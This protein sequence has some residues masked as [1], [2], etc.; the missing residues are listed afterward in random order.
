MPH[1]ARHTR[2]GSLATCV[3]VRHDRES[4]EGT[5]TDRGGRAGRDDG[6]WA[7]KAYRCYGGA[8]PPR[9]RPARPPGSLAPLRHGAPHLARTL[10]V[11]WVGITRGGLGIPYVGRIHR[12]RPRDTFLELTARGQPGPIALRAL[13]R[14]GTE[15]INLVPIEEAGRDAHRILARSLSHPARQQKKLWTLAS[16][17]DWQSIQHPL[18]R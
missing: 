12:S 8:S 2:L 16:G 3:I 15:S 17:S 7:G 10:M 9:S 18:E 5:M 6:W 14:R 11:P 13:R 4:S 1:P